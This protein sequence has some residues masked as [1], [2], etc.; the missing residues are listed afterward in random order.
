MATAYFDV[1]GTL[2][3]TNLLHPTFHYLTNQATPARSALRL[4]KA[5]LDAPRLAW[6]EVRDRRRFNE[7]LF[8]HYR[9]MSEDRL[10]VLADEIFEE[11]ALPRL[12]PGSVELVDA[13]KRAGFRVVL[14]TGALDFN[15]APLLKHLGAQAAICNRLEFKDGY[16]TG[17]LLR[18]VVA[19]PGKARLI[20]DD[21]RQAGH[22]LA[23]C[24][25]YSD[26]FSDVPMLSLVGHPFCV[27]PDGKLQRLAEAY[28]WP[29]LDLAHRSRGE[30]APEARA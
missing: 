17:K 2:V 30:R 19:G 9:G 15:T 11:V 26:S 29:I 14:I 28:D 4:G 21:A 5:L 16:A 6:A 25:A 22:D 20:A 1:D 8:A 12:R 18:P 23:H 7:L 24:H 13:C 27:H 10:L 3:S